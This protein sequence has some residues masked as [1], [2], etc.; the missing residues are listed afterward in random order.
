MNNNNFSSEYYFIFICYPSIKRDSRIYIRLHL[1]FFFFFF[2]AKSCAMGSQRARS[3]WGGLSVCGNQSKLQPYWHR[4]HARL[5][6][7]A[8]KLLLFCPGRSITRTHSTDQHIID[9]PTR[10]RCSKVGH[11]ARNPRSNNAGWVL[12]AVFERVSAAACLCVNLPNW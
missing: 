7:S 6:T 11:V 4:L 8:R 3:R 2:H 5:R 9:A 1:N 10:R 12:S